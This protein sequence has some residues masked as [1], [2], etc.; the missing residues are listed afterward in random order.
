MMNQEAQLETIEQDYWSRES[1]LLCV[2]YTRKSLP[3]NVKVMSA[4][5]VS[6]CVEGTVGG[7]TEEG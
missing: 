7:G 1:I 3:R 4:F 6:V 2:G 5:P